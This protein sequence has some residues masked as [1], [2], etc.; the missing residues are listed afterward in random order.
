[1]HV[2]LHGHFATFHSR[3]TR[4]HGARKS[5]TP[6]RTAQDLDHGLSMLTREHIKRPFSSKGYRISTRLH[7]LSVIA[8]AEE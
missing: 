6:V 4:A 7:P 8:L 1:M 2:D 3:G 5:S